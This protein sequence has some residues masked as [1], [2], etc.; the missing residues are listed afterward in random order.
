MAQ[1]RHGTVEGDNAAVGARLHHPAL[2]HG[3]NEQ[4]ELVE[5]GVG[6]QPLRGILEKL[7]YRARPAVEVGGDLVV[8][9]LARRINLQGETPDGAGKSKVS[10]QDL[11]TI[12]VEQDKDA[13]YGIL[14][15]G[16][17]RVQ[18]DGIKMSQVPLENGL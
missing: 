8:N 3:E 5:V 9:P 12:V 2:H 15:G 11:L 17:N 1:L 6:G 10:H 14:G 13:L 18:D 4:S 16:A 7:T